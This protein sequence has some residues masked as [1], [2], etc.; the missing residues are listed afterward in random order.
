VLEFLTSS[1][2]QKPNKNTV[3]EVMQKADSNSSAGAAADSEQ[4]VEDTSVSQ[5]SRKPHV[6]PTPSVKTCYLKV[7]I[8]LSESKLFC[9]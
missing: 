3:V 4:K 6:E 9:C 8:Y 1:P 2:V 7:I 5:H